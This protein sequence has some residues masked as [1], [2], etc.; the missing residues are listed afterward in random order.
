[1]GNKKLIE[2]TWAQETGRT[3]EGFHRFIGES[4]FFIFL[5][6]LQIQRIT[7]FFRENG[8]ISENESVISDNS[9]VT[10]VLNIGFSFLKKLISIR[11]KNICTIK[12]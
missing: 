7:M 1:M 3:S 12:E 2:F 4:I 10:E 5:F 9:K 11:K 8:S 6:F